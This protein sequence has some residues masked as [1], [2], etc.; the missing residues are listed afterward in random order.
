MSAR[1][2]RTLRRT[3][4]LVVVAVVLVFAADRATPA[5]PFNLIAGPYARLLAQ[6]V[7][8][9]PA[10]GD[11]VQ[12]TAELRDGARPVAL[13]EWARDH[14]LSV[15]WRDGDGWA[16]LD[17]TPR[18]LAGALDVSVHDYRGRRGQVFYASPQQPG[19][20]E[21]LRGEVTE[22]GRILGY[23]PYHEGAPPTPPLDVPDGGLMPT[24][25]LTA[26]NV[27]A[28]AAAGFTGAGMT[29]AVFTFDGF[30]QRDMDSFADWFSLPRFT[31]E[32]MGGMPTQKRG[33]ATMDIQLIHAIAPAA[34]IVL[35]NARSTV[36]G[37]AAYVKLGKLMES[38]DQRYP[39]AVWSF[40]IGWGC[41]RV[42]TEGRSG[43]GAIGALTS[44]PQRDDGVRRQR[45]PGRPGMQR[46]SR[47]VGFAE[48]GRHRRGCG[49]LGPGDD[50][51]RW[52][53][54]VHRRPRAMAGR[55]GVVRR[56]AHPGQ[57]RRL[58]GAVRP[59]ALAGGSR[60]CRPARQTAGARCRRGR[61]PVH[62]GEVRV[63][64][65]GAR[66]RRNVAGGADLGRA[67]RR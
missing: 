14:G 7:D 57:W 26:Y 15:S 63:P 27:D 65:A 1:R 2:P 29:V 16:V 50:R 10:R 4:L 39:G 62:R 19:V 44:P 45:R 55:A 31:P 51:G 47:L 28:L 17:G 25:L 8:L 5:V 35:V 43:A 20:P 67:W 33:E 41:D 32:V 30:D 40:S 61:R 36:E 37:D 6:A 58:V 54:V 64:P 3:P 49:G 11:H 18:A 34:K 48:P 42:M 60:A 52:H 12:L 53:H 56:A 23:T 66:R 22:L 38:V 21:Q 24:E 13:T 9:G 59:A 46:R